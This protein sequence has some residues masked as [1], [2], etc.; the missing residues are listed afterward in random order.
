MDAKYSSL[1]EIPG[2]PYTGVALIDLLECQ[3]I[4]T[5]P[6]VPVRR[7]WAFLGRLGLRITSAKVDHVEPHTTRNAF[8]ETC[9]KTCNYGI[10]F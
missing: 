4:P 6:S 8:L 3:F 10:H 9:S 2:E 5:D 7:P 1:S